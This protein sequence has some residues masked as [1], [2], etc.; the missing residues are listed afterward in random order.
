[1]AHAHCILDTQGYKHTLRICNT[2]FIS[3]VTKVARTR[4]NVTLYVH[5]LSCFC[6]TEVVRVFFFNNCFVHHNS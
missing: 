4:L 2:Y 5:L 1:M 3:T 6:I